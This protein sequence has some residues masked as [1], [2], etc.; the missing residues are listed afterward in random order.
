MFLSTLSDE[1]SFKSGLIRFH[2]TWAFCTELNNFA[3]FEDLVE[4]FV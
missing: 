3:A 4:S 2:E 1:V